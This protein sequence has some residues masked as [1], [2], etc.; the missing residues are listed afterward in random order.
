[1]DIFTTQNLIILGII[2]ALGIGFGA[3]LQLTWMMRILIASYIALCL[4]LIIPNNLL[5]NEYAQIIYFF[6]ILAIFTLVEKSR[7]FDVANWTVGRFSFEAL[8]LSVLTVFFISAIIC[9]LLSFKQCNIIISRDIY[10]MFNDYIFYIA[11][12]PLIFT[13]L[14]SKRLH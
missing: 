10:N 12:A 2:F 11:L 14:F 4:V 1:M 3:T 5:F 9:L 8:G 13:I 7:F 6:G